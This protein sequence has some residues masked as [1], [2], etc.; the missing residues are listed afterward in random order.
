[1]GTEPRPRGHR[2]T[3]ESTAGT[4]ALTVFLLRREISA[5]DQALADQ[6]NPL[7]RYELRSGLPF[8]GALYLRRPRS[9]VPS[10]VGFVGPGVEGNL[11]ALT[12]STG[13][14]LFVRSSGH[15]FALTFGAGRHLLDTDAVEQDFGLRVTLNSVD[16]SS[17]RS[18]DLQTVEETT[19]LTR[20]Q[21]SR[22]S[23]VEVFG[24][25]V[26]RDMLR[27]VSG[28]PRDTSLAVSLGGATALAL[29]S[30]VTF[31]QIG[32][33]CEQLL[34]AYNDKRYQEHFP[35]IDYMRRVR[36]GDLVNQLDES[37]LAALNDRRLEKLYLAVPEQVPWDSLAGFQ[38]SVDAQRASL[39]DD[40]DPATYLD[41]LKDRPRGKRPLQLSDLKGDKT[42]AVSSGDDEAIAKW[43][44]YRT[45]VFETALGDR[46]YVLSGGEWYEVE[47]DFAQRTSQLVRD[48]PDAGIPFPAVNPGEREG[49]YLRRVAPIVTEQTGVYFT[50]FDGQLVRCANA[51]TSIE[52]CDLFSQMG[53]FVHVKRRTRS[54]TLS[55]LF[56]QGTV[57]AEAFISDSQFRCD[58]GLLA[59]GTPCADLISEAQP[60]TAD[61]TV[62]YGVAVAGNASFHDSLPFFSR[63]TLAHAA[64]LL[65]TW[66]FQVATARIQQ[67]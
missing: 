52:V 32:S 35:W 34:A 46:N 42:M 26:A 63:V 19:L 44:L 16:P 6:R 5:P 60:K 24:I 17:L 64:R 18:V 56:A 1:M 53:H 39:H 47:P 10:W 2:P 12:A 28:E 20:R 62:V 22:R 15:W 45:I 59:D 54:S 27:A 9:R 37:L 31:E 61:Y 21:A 11:N 66:G 67:T 23:G 8:D 57:S 14:V 29:R 7:T 13:A 30:A 58:A 4:V 50:V 49:D 3:V 65:R 40:L 25:D 55:H 41:L 36:E 38:Y 43:P 48:L 33:K 51:S